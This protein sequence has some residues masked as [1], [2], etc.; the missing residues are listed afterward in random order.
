MAA[1]KLRDQWVVW[2]AGCLVAAGVFWVWSV[3]TLMMIG[4]SLWLARRQACA[5]WRAADAVWHGG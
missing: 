3:W 5:A 1:L 2:I 4:R